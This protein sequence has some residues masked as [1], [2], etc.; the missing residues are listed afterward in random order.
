MKLIGL[1]GGIASGK[2]TVA[3]FFAAKGIPVLDADQMAKAV[4]TPAMVSDTFGTEFLVNGEIDRKK[5]GTFVFEHPAERE[6]LEALTHPLIAKQLQEAMMTL[7]NAPLIIYEA[8]L[9]FEK[10]L[11]DRF[12]ATILVTTS[13]ET[14]LSRL[15]KRDGLTKEE[16]L[17]RIG[18]Q[19]PDAEKRLLATYVINNYD[20]LEDLKR[21]V[22]SLEIGRA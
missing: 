17:A 10:G 1:T 6:K 18:A 8:S 16:A 13:D 5:L 22:D 12:N 9:I 19:M 4:L 21:Q 14:R 11:Q 7:E 15:M 20:D 3:T 2:S